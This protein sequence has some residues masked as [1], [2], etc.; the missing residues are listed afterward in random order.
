[1]DLQRRHRRAGGRTI[2]GS[3]CSLVVACLVVSGCASS[4]A[5]P[6]QADGDRSTGP[7]SLVPPSD[8]VMEAA[9]D[10]ELV[11]QDGCIGLST[12]GERFIELVWHEDDVEWRASDSAVLFQG[13][14]LRLG[15]VVGLG[16]GFTTPAA[17]TSRPASCEAVSETFVVGSVRS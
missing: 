6:P 14:P 10:G 5:T 9:V 17:H 7:L 1:M 3:V 16:G 13:S 11:A 12:S 2:A 15:E 8:A 4:K